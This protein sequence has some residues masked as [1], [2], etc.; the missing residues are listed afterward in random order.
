MKNSKLISEMISS[1]ALVPELF[2]PGFYRQEVFQLVQKPKINF[3]T[4]DE[5]TNLVYTRF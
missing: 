4:N 1:L 2:I 3:V 5:E